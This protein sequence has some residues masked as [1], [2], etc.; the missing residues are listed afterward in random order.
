[1]LFTYVNNTYVWNQVS[2]RSTEK[3]RFTTSINMKAPSLNLFRELVLKAGEKIRPESVI[4]SFED[5]CVSDA[6]DGTQDDILWQDD[7]DE[8][9]E[10]LINDRYSDERSDDWDAYYDL[11]VDHKSINNYDICKMQKNS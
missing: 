3:K 6:L 10:D 11:N 2:G 7:Q 8:Q 1:M 5:C 4:K 9:N